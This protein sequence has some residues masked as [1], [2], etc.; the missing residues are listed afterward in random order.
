MHETLIV[1]YLEEL[2]KLRESTKQFEKSSEYRRPDQ[3]R[4]DIAE[5]RQSLLK[6]LTTSHAYRP[7]VVIKNFP[8]N[9]NDLL[10]EKAIVLAR[11]YFILF[12]S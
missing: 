6:F 9:D 2:E 8:R 3:E 10:E 4:K 5:I 11:F 7:E 12:Y 1:L